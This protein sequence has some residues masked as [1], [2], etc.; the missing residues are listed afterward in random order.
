MSEVTRTRPSL[1]T[2]VFFMLQGR[3]A[4]PLAERPDS[5][6]CFPLFLKSFHPL[7]F[8]PNP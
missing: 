1:E 2:G 8:R 3:P 6:R 5:L 4:E 7:R